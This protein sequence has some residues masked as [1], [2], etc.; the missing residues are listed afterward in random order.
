MRNT[1]QRNK[2]VEI[3]N[4]LS[5]FAN[6]FSVIR[7]VGFKKIVTKVE[8]TLSNIESQMAVGGFKYHQWFCLVNPNGH[9]SVI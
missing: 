8:F 5:F 3:L 6:S 1:R 7:L 9:K 2:D 4:Q